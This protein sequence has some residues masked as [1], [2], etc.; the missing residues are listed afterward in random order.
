MRGPVEARRL[1][2]RLHRSGRLAEP[3][4]EELRVFLS[5][6]VAGRGGRRAPR[7]HPRALGRALGLSRRQVDGALAALE[8][9]GWVRVN[10]RTRPW[11][12]RFESRPL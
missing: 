7:Y 4:R 9:R 5:L 12:V 1:L 10:R 8:R 6:L 2:R 11:T 3:G